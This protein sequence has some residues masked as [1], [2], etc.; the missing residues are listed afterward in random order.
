LRNNDFLSRQE[1]LSG[2]ELRELHRILQK[3]ALQAY[4]NPERIGCPGTAVLRE[5]AA[6]SWPSDH[7]AY[8]HVKTCSP[9]LR[10]MLE[11]GEAIDR[12][13]RRRRM[14]NFSAI[15]AGILVISGISLQVWRMHLQTMSHAAIMNFATS[16]YRGAERTK[17]P[18]PE[19]QSY[20]RAQLLLTVNLPPG[21][22]DGEY[23]FQIVPANS[24]AP[25][26]Q[27][28]GQATIAHGLTTFRTK[29]DLTHVEP[30]IYKARARRVPLG[31]WQNLTIQV[32]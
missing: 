4:P 25:L 14:R 17:Q 3:A 32:R 20:P 31:E 11:L 21:S 5:V 2:D 10:E 26:L 7:E 8:Q 28:N 27:V 15:A 24:E 1:P 29:I 6:A 18:V 30:G 13:R 23:E 16:V 12:E 19:M 9:C 22:D